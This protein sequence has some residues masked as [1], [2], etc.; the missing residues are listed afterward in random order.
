MGKRP[1]IRIGSLLSR[2]D[3]SAELKTL[4]KL[5]KQFS[6]YYGRQ[7]DLCS[8][9]G[10]NSRTSETLLKEQ[11]QEIMKTLQ[12]FKLTNA[13]DGAS[14]IEGFEQ[15]DN[16]RQFPYNARNFQQKIKTT[17]YF[18]HAKKLTPMIDQYNT[19]K[20]PED[21]QKVED[22]IASLSDNELFGV[23]NSAIDRFKE[24][25]TDDKLTETNTLLGYFHK[26]IVKE[27][28]KS[29]IN[30]HNVKENAAFDFNSR[31][32]ERADFNGGFYTISREDLARHN[33]FSEAYQNFTQQ[34]HKPLTTRDDYDLSACPAWQACRQSDNFTILE[35]YVKASMARLRI[36]P[37]I[38]KDINAVDIMDIMTPDEYA[39]RDK[40]RFISFQKLNP[41]CHEGERKTFIDSLDRQELDRAVSIV[42]VGHGDSNSIEVHHFDPINARGKGANNGL[43]QIM[44]V[45]GNEERCYKNDIEDTNIHR[46]TH[47]GD[48]V[49]RPNIQKKSPTEPDYIPVELDERHNG[50]IMFHMIDTRA[51]ECYENNQIMVM[52][53]VRKKDVTTIDL[54]TKMTNLS[55]TKISQQGVSR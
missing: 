23:L 18:E 12:E 25:P 2:H 15:L 42:S 47:R 30:S 50:D 55:K 16:K 7:L 52:A 48:L 54:P 35:P 21:K 10:N 22:Y 4:D 1:R 41:L 34:R 9:Y 36:D 43:Y 20:S 29:S 17:L 49:L 14:F 19:S 5:N 28:Y 3:N 40:S 45:D 32:T 8:R 11:K 46:F 24:H 6:A 51:E 13:K 38:L 53:G 39:H 44:V 26:Q 37:Q 27:E 31:K 33:P